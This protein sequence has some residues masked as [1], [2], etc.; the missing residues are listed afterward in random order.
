M[1]PGARSGAPIPFRALDR[2]PHPRPRALLFGTYDPTHTRN[3]VIP[4]LLTTAGWDTTTIRR[5]LWGAQ[6]FS[7]LRTGRLRL[8]GRAAAVYAVL[9]VRA[10]TSRRP[11]VVMILYPGHFDMLLLAPIWRMRRVPVVFDPLLA[12]H[13]TTV[14]DRRLVPENTVASR[15]IA[16]ADR[17]AFRLADLVL[18]DTPQVGAYYTERYGLP[19]ARQLVVWPGTD[20]TALGPQATDEGRARRVFFHGSFIALHG[21][22]TIVR[23]AAASDPEIEFVVVGAGQESDAIAELIEDLGG[24]P[25]LTIRPPASLT[26]IGDEIRDASICLGIFGTTPKARRVVPFK[27]FEY[28]AL[29]RPVITGDTPA[30]RHALGDDVI[31]VPA[32]DPEALVRAIAELVADAPSRIA[33]GHRGRVRFAADFG[34]D[35]QARTLGTALAA[36]AGR[37]KR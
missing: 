27:V 34:H 1:E 15:L 19:C 26:A 14:V 7:S 33:L 6:R 3:R 37:R 12:L 25:N 16:R 35:A 28:L 4:Q 18:V 20:E 31:L 10:L 36:L 29:G 30:A 17:M 2:L 13:D 8:L 5:D 9:A 32:G 24:V 21:I 11:D 22:D 23:A